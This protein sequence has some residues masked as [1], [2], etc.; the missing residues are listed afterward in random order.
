M[1]FEVYL[2]PAVVSTHEPRK[3]LDEGPPREPRVAKW[4]Y[5]WLPIQPVCLSFSHINCRMKAVMVSLPCPLIINA[6][7]NSV[8]PQKIPS[9]RPTMQDA[10]C[11]LITSTGS[12][13]VMWQSGKPS[14]CFCL[15]QDQHH[16]E[17]CTGDSLKFQVNCR[18][19]LSC[20]AL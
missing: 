4:G 3:R 14:P 9:S 11:R 5:E 18:G 6:L 17:T 15:K 19:F 7:H 20:S 8:I 16:A 1:L 13:L 12:C 10:A 2:C